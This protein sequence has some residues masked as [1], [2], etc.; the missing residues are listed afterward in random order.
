MVEVWIDQTSPVESFIMGTI[1]LASIAC[2]NV[3]CRLSYSPQVIERQFFISSA[4]LVDIGG[5]Y[6]AVAFRGDG[7]E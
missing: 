4:Y 6:C 7:G 2:G 1:N 3:S 5:I